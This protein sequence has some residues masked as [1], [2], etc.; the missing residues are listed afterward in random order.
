MSIITVEKNL[1]IDALQDITIDSLSEL[2]LPGAED[3]TAPMQELGD[4]VKL[5][6]NAQVGLLF[7]ENAI[8]ELKAYDGPITFNLEKVTNATNVELNLTILEYLGVSASDVFGA[9]TTFTTGEAGSARNSVTIQPVPESATAT[10]SL[11]ALAGF[12]ARRRK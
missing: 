12:C 7:T 10:L 8:N 2:A 9:N 4:G 11:L 1:N 5:G 6:D 3:G